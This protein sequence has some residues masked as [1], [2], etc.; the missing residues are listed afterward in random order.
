[1]LYLTVII[2]ATALTAAVNI[3]LSPITAQNIYSVCLSSLS[4]TIS[5]ILIDGLGALIIRRLLPESLFEPRRKIFTVSKKEYQLYRKL[6]IK[7]WKDKIPELGGFT[8]FHKD[9][10]ASAS[11]Q[12]YLE[13]FLLESNYGV[14]IH[15]QNA[16]FGFLIFFIPVCSSPSIWIPVFIVNFI[17]SLLPVAVLRHNSYTLLRLYNRALKKQEEKN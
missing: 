17:L 12:S 9:K 11:D 5:V 3:L 16:I 8:S 13:R 15:I 7:S 4:A 2:L 14:I 10:L 1:M 6:K